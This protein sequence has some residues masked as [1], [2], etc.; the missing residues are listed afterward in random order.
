MSIFPNG[1]FAV[2]KMQSHDKD[3]LD[4]GPRGFNCGCFELTRDNPKMTDN[5]AVKPKA[6]SPCTTP[7]CNNKLLSQAIGHP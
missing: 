6:I 4:Q 1:A 5:R 7:L 3:V 2:V